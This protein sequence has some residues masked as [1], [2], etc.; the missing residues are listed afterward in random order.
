ML[1][2]YIRIVILIIVMGKTDGTDSGQMPTGPA[3]R[4]ETCE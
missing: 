1:M 3:K 4:E 2:G